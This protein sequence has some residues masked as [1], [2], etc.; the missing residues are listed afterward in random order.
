VLLDGL[1]EQGPVFGLLHGLE[2]QRRV[3]GRVLR[4]GNAEL[5]EVTG[6]G[7]HGGPLAEGIELVHEII[8]LCGLMTSPARSCASADVFMRTVA[9]VFARCIG[10]LP[11]GLS[12]GRPALQGLWSVTDGG[13]RR[14]GLP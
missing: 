5:L 9:R 8:I 6:V 1:V 11:A 14:P 2:D 3:G 12:V 10:L 7:D 13:A 4:L